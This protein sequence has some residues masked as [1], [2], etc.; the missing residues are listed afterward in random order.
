MAMIYC[1]RQ[2]VSH[3]KWHYTGCSDEGGLAHPVGDCAN[4]C[5]GHATAADARQH[6]VEG[7]I[8]DAVFR[9]LPRVECDFP[10]CSAAANICAEVGL[11]V[12]QFFNLCSVHS[13]RTCLHALYR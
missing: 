9:P 1:P 12:P 4:G 7:A 13:D 5:P 3:G 11:H 2:R 10:G 6:Y 8:R